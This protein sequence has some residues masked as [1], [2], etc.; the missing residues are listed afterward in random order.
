MQRRQLRHHRPGGT[1]RRIRLPGHRDVVERPDRQR[2][3]QP[4]QRGV[5]LQEP[6]HRARGQRLQLVHRRGLRRHQRRRQ[7]LHAQP[8][9]RLPEVLVAD[10]PLPQPRTL[11]HHR[12]QLLRGRVQ[13]QLRVPLRPRG[14]AYLA[15]R[16]REVLEVVPAH[17][18]HLPLRTTP[19][20]HQL[21]DHH[22]HRRHQHQHT[23]DAHERSRARHEEEDDG[24]THAEHRQELHQHAL[25]LPARKFGRSLQSQLLRR[26]L[27]RQ[28]PRRAFDD[29]L[30]HR[31]INPSKTDGT[32]QPAPPSPGREGGI[33]HATVILLADSR[34]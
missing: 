6:L 33:P 24:G 18:G 20:A 30:A 2:H 7:A 17:I 27:R 11:R 5:H 3:R 31:S 28:G 13:I 23:H 21:R 19:V 16:L 4:V 25:L 29:D 9:P 32:S 8:Q 26:N 15:T 12:P 22:G 14:P 10:P 1:A 34:S